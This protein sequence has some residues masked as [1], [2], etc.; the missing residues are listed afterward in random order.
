MAMKRALLA[1]TV[2]LLLASAA[3]SDELVHVLARGETVYTLARRYD[4]SPE[5]ILSYNAI[6]DPTRL[7][8]GTRIR[9]PGSYVV[10]DGEYVYAIAQ[11]LGIDW[12]DLLEVNG[13]GRDDVVRPG[14]VLM[15]PRAG[16]AVAA[17]EPRSGPEASGT[18]SR[19][20]GTSS[21]TASAAAPAA[22]GAAPASGPELPAGA[23]ANTVSRWP[24]PGERE[25]WEGKF[26]GTVMRGREGD[27]FRS[28]SRGTVEYV[29]PFSSFGKLILVRSDNGY[30]YG[31]AGADRVAVSAGDSVS[32][33]T[34]LGTV[35]FSPAFDSAMVLFT[36]WRNNRYVDPETA[37]RG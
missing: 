18:G 2:V 6:A 11:R 13:L 23:A 7:A 36:V 17:P 3:W 20:N 8:V 32:N 14:D 33:G 25:I 1:T 30:L 21:G 27:E 37:P 4:V 29:G 26:P 24:H 34:V 10:K 31:Y 19:A 5:A 22:V 16:S 12:L 15:V 35:G 28:V 9:I